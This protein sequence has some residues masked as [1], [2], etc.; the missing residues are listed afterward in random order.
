ML[1]I[2][3]GQSIANRLANQL[4]KKDKV[5]RNKLQ[6]TNEACSTIPPLTYEAV[7]DIDSSTWKEVGDLAV[8]QHVPMLVISAAVDHHNFVSRASE[9][10]GHVEKEI[11]SVLKYF[12]SQHSI[13]LDSLQIHD[14]EGSKAAIIEKG[15]SIEYQ[16]SQFYLK[17][18]NIAQ[19]D[20]QTLSNFKEIVEANRVSSAEIENIIREIEE[21]EEVGTSHN[22]PTDEVMERSPNETSEDDDESEEEDSDHPE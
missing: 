13:L 1:L 8:G 21:M 14:E 17:I 12:K 3:G 7:K 11:A 9:E 10:M 15:L 18:K 2:T 5:I 16:A 22:Q 4:Q 19:G 6:V 20:A